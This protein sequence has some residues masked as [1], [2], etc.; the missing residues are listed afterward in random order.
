M[1]RIINISF[2]GVF[3]SSTSFAQDLRDVKPPVNVP[4]PLWI[5]S[6][7]IVVS[8]AVL[9]AAVYTFKKL[10][11]KAKK[12]TVLSPWD[13][14]LREFN[15]LM[16]KQLVASGHVKEHYAQLS[17]IV[18]TYIENRFELKA[19]EM[20]TEEFLI[21]LNNTSRLTSDQKRLLREFLTQCDLV[22]FARYTPEVDEIQKSLDLAIKF[23]QETKQS[24]MGRV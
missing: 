18:R 20:T 22:K 16:N 11:K 4:W 1:K 12:D 21:S 9:M 5:K 23:V 15:E 13:M 17:Q 19:P 8:L 14:A 10:R 2:F 24:E 6:L 3:L 7:V